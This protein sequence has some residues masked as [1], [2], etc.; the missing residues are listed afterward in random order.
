MANEYIETHVKIKLAVKNNRKTNL[1]Y[2]FHSRTILTS[3]INRHC[4]NISAKNM[5]NNK[6]TIGPIKLILNMTLNIM[7][8]DKR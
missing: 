2:I 7:I 3:R 4:I 1:K 5:T 8:V 6:R